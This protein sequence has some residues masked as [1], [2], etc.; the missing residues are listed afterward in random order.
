MV[1]IGMK[2]PFMVIIT[3][4]DENID[5]SPFYTLENVKVEVINKGDE[6]VRKGEFIKYM[7]HS[8]ISLTRTFASDENG[9]E[10]AECFARNLPVLLKQNTAT[11]E[12]IYYWAVASRDGFEW[13]ISPQEIE[14]LTQVKSTLALSWYIP[15]KSINIAQ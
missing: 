13:E 2:E 1:Y 10:W 6:V 14:L 15:Q 8:S 11:A 9:R 4:I 3:L 7:N 5:P 12:V